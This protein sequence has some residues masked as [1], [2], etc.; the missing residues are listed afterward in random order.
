M[1]KEKKIELSPCKTSYHRFCNSQNCCFYA[2]NFVTFAN[3]YDCANAMD[4]IRL[5]VLAAV[6]MPDRPMGLASQLP[7]DERNLK[8]IECG[9]NVRRKPKKRET[10]RQRERDEFELI[11]SAGSDM[12]DLRC[13]QY[14]SN[15]VVDADTRAHA[16]H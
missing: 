9:R 8:V 5:N 10:G 11:N 4:W 1:K 2:M 3:G 16:L 7:S 6:A 13:I 14:R 15:G 12:C